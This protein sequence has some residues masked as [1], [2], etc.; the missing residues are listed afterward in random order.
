MPVTQNDLD[1]NV[2]RIV[3][4]LTPY[5][6]WIGDCLKYHG[7]ALTGDHKHYCPDWDFRPIDSTCDE[8]EGCNC[9]GVP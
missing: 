8:F 9:Y 1:E 3:G 6:D 7:Y 5:D 2:P 4:K